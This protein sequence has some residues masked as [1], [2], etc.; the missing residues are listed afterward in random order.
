MQMTPPCT[1]L[2]TLLRSLVLYWKG[3]LNRLAVWVSDNGLTLNENKNQ[4]LLLSRK[5]RAND[6]ENVRVSL[7]GHRVQKGGRACIIIL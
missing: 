5:G 7:F 1:M 2:L 6:L 3:T 4:L